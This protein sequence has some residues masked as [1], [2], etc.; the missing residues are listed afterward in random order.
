MDTLVKYEDIVE[1]MS[2]AP[3]FGQI[4]G[5]YAVARIGD[6]PSDCMQRSY[7]PAQTEGMAIMLVLSGS[8]DIEVNMTD[9]HIGGDSLLIVPPRT[10]VQVHSNEDTENAAELYMLFM[11]PN[12]LHEININ[13][14][15]LSMPVPFEKPSPVRPLKPEQTVLMSRYFR[16]LTEVTRNQANLR[17][18][19]NIASSLVSAMIYQVAQFC[20]KE[21]AD[22][23]PRAETAGNRPSNYV[24]EFIR[25]L[26]LHYMNE[27]SVTFYADKLFISP[28]Y[29]SLLVKKAT[30]RSA[31]RWID[32]RVVMEARNLL[33]YSG[34]N[35]QQVAY[36]LNFSNQSAFGKYFKHLTGMSPTEYQKG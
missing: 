7:R 17:L 9:Y 10:L 24:N 29:L 12:F 18:D 5:A 3:D 2:K 28:K 31:S 26:Q 20:Y 14:A 6:E 23:S 19:T 13:Y 15:A 4:P 25:L 27:R 21:L 11:S 22:N 35:I 8:V 1:L 16:L 33:R 30:G 32:D 36:M 34:K